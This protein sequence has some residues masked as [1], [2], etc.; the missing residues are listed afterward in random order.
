MEFI[1]KLLTFLNSIG[2]AYLIFLFYKKNLPKQADLKS[3]QTLDSQLKIKL[4]RF[5][6]FDEIGSN[7]S[8]ILCLLDMDNS[9]VIITSLHSRDQTRIYAK[10]IKEGNIDPNIF[11]KKEKEILSKI[12]KN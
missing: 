12:I 10:E 7:Q 5:N 3:K 2:I 11:S 9:G 8:F 4:V 1:F 6:P